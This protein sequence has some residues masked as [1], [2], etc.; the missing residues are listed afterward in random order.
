VVGTEHGFGGDRLATRGAKDFS[1]SKVVKL[2]VT[3]GTADV[4]AEVKRFAATL[5]RI[6]GS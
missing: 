3:N 6:P 2:T 1:A 5:R 4:N